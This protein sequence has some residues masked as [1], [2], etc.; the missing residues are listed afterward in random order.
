MCSTELFVNWNIFILSWSDISL[1]RYLLQSKI[2]VCHSCWDCVYWKS[3]I[4]SY[5]L[6]PWG[7]FFLWHCD[8]L[9]FWMDLF[10]IDVL[11]KFMIWYWWQSP[12]LLIP[13]KKLF[14]TGNAN[15]KNW[16]CCLNQRPSDVNIFHVPPLAWFSIVDFNVLFLIYTC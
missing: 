13:S 8:L 4:L 16:Q 3:S 5:I 10:K 14:L 2:F 15:V 9:H 11:R 7:S 12:L 1:H 6:I